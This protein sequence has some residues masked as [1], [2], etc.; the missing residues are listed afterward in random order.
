MAEAR[1]ITGLKIV[2]EI[3]E[4]TAVDMVAE[5]ADVLQVGARNMQN[6]HLLKAVG[7]AG[8]PVLLKR[9]ISATIS[10]WLHAAE[11]ILN[12]G[13]YNV[14]LCERGI[15]TFEEYTATH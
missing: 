4:V 1:E 9:G 11:Y 15:R 8:K 3:T 7:R 14:M 6:F 13:N 12:E 2:T 10:E 5:Y